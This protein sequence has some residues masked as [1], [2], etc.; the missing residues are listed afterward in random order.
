MTFDINDLDSVL[1]ALTTELV[2]NGP[3]TAAQLTKKA[4]MADA[5]MDEDQMNELLFMFAEEGAVRVDDDGVWS[6]AA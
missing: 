4:L 3:Q 5:D 6:V 2:E 1:N